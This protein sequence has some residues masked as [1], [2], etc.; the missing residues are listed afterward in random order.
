MHDGT[1]SRQIRKIFCPHA[2]QCGPSVVRIRRELMQAHYALMTE[3][4]LEG[5]MMKR[6]LLA[7]TALG[8]SAGLA[9]ADVTVG[10]DGRM[11]VVV[12]NDENMKLSSR[13][14]ISFTASAELDGGMTAGGSIR[15]DNAGGG[16]S[17]T[18]GS[19]FL[20]GAFG[21]LS[22]GDVDP[23]AKA[24]VGH[25]DGVGYTGLGDLNEISYLRGAHSTDADSLNLEDPTLLYTL[26]KMG[27]V[28]VYAS[29][30][31]Q[32][33]EG[34]T[35]AQEINGE[36]IA[37]G[38]HVEL[39]FGDMEMMDKAWIAGALESSTDDHDAHLVVGAGVSA[40]GFTGKLVAGTRDTD[41]GAQNQFAI[42]GGY[43]AG[44]I[45]TTV[46][47][48]D[49]YEMGGAEAIGAGLSWSLG[50][51]AAIKAGVATEIGQG[52]DDDIRTA[53]LGVTFSF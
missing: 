2:E 5:N 31:Q 27:D 13:V 4:P 38:A 25:V 47:Y 43:S 34:S 19:V 3:K 44:Q 11:G 32:N 49:D 21:K 46:F 39:P 20:M 52:T 37:L 29:V 51:G 48:A 23:A 8:M 30:G 6:L 36:T 24:A 45:G 42:S 28:Q 35:T 50:G 18:G 12:D 1:D 17:G 16:T 14:R 33:V 7:T 53:D 41:D 9:M 22:A 10:G 26:P 40:S 15:A